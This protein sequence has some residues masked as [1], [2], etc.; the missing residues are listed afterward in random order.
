MAESLTRAE[1]IMEDTVTL[2]NYIL[3]KKEINMC[4]ISTL[5]YAIN[6]LYEEGYIFDDRLLGNLKDAI[7]N[8]KRGGKL[9]K[10]MELS[11]KLIRDKIKDLRR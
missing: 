10:P 2:I 9:T 8:L 5:S 7:S 3:E 11:L 1:R 4:Q 6:I